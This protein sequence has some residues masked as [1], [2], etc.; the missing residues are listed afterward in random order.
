MTP[1]ERAHAILQRHDA[2]IFDELVRLYRRVDELEAAAARDT[3]P[4]PSIDLV[5]GHLDDDDGSIGDGVSI[6]TTSERP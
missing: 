2:T 3:D 6:L 5:A 4:A 1:A